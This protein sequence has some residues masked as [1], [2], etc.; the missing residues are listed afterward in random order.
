M[1]LP[2]RIAY[3]R[4][5]LT[6][7]RCAKSQIQ[8]CGIDLSLK[9]VLTLES[10]GCIDFDNT[11]R[12]TAGSVVLPFTGETLEYVHLHQGVYLVE[13]NEFI[14][15][16]RNIMG[17][18][19]VRSS[20]FRSGIQIH[21]GVVDSGYQGVIGAMLKVENSFGLRVYKDARLAQMVFHELTE[22]T[23]GYSGQYQGSAKL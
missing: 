23:E 5:N 4:G 3:A 18:I 13:F 10:A 21:A 16:P 12:Q 7:I 11:H 22:P 9:Q 14:R 19:F 15:T 20:L 2:G 1:I 17:Q 6:N 8:P